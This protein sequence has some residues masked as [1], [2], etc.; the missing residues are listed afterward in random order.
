M[1]LYDCEFVGRNKDDS[2]SPHKCKF[3]FKH[4]KDLNAGEVRH[5]LIHTHDFKDITMLD[6]YKTSVGYN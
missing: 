4:D 1:K 6:V 2:R 5:E 3:S